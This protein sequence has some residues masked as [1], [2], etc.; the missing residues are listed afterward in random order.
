MVKKNDIVH[1]IQWHDGMPLAPHHFQQ[2]NLRYQQIISHHLNYLSFHHYGIQNLQ[3]D[4]ILLPSGVF[5]IQSADI[6]MQD[7][8]V[9]KYDITEEGISLLECSLAPK[10]AEMESKPVIVQLL[11]PQRIPGI[12]PLGGASP[13]FSSKVGKE[14]N[15]ENTDDNPI[16]IPRLIPKFE[17]QLGS[18]LPPKYICFP[19]AKVKFEDG[20]FKISEYTPPC[21]FIEEKSM[22]LKKSTVVV[23]K[24]REKTQTFSEKW[25]NQVGSN[26][27]RETADVLKPLITVLPLLEMLVSSQFIQPYSLYC[28]LV[29]AAGIISQLTLSKVPQK[30]A[31][32]NHNS[33]DECI[34]PILEYITECIERIC[35][36]Y[37][38]FS[39][40]R[41][42]KIF[43][44]KLHHSYINNNELLVGVR[45]K[46]GIRH[47]QIED[48]MNEAVI[49]SDGA[50]QKV[51]EKRVLGTARGLINDDRLYKMSPPRDVTM[52]SVIVDQNFI[53][54]N[55]YMHIF[56]QSDDEKKRPLD[57]VL[58]VPK[59]PENS[60]VNDSAAA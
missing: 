40:I 46:Q 55:Q 35:L 15:D 10:Q 51:K 30:F 21:F 1:I 14:V 16:S 33:I 25:Q 47:N 19:I 8:L 36:E 29:R 13:R 48:W 26:L 52:F 56:N 57:I 34:E 31:A 58:Y 38:I 44:V 41:N 54:I 53:T 22:I 20:V 43:S 37:T 23:R 59:T 42:D 32:Y 49:V 17:L 4:Q 7:G 9:Y 12:S 3:I 2:Q 27:L 28:E 50:L 45:A 24:I 5:R 60:S 39:F 6:V 11:I 18:D